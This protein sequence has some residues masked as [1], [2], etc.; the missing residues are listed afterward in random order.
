ME[1]KFPVLPHA[2]LAGEQMLPFGAV[3]DLGSINL[4]VFVDIQN[5]KFKLDEIKK[6]TKN[7]VRILDNVNDYTDAPLPEYVESVRKR[8]RIGIGVMGWG[9]ALYLLRVRFGSDEAES[10]KH[11]LMQTITYSAVVS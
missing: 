2:T 10:I 4:A 1:A 11:E 7:L 6:H 3:C 5:R 8:R 9:S